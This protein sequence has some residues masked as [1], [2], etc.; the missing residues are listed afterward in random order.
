VPARGGARPP[1]RTSAARAAALLGHW[2]LLTAATEYRR[3]VGRVGEARGRRRR[4]VA[5]FCW[6][7]GPRRRKPS[8][9]LAPRRLSG[10]FPPCARLPNS[11]HLTSVHNSRCK[12]C[13][14]AE[15]RCGVRS[16]GVQA[17]CVPPRAAART[18]LQTAQ[19]LRAAPDG[20]LKRRKRAFSRFGATKRAAW[21]G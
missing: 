8:P 17:R 16:T 9:G 1:V 19:G 18:Q 5:L 6:L 20:A 7:H 10:E 12:K 13:S 11:S 3:W 4:R 14:L 15:E 21:R 2:A